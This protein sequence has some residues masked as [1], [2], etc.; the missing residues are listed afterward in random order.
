M[1]ELIG[2]S[3]KVLVIFPVDHCRVEARQQSEEDY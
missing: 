3:V 1:Q 2:K